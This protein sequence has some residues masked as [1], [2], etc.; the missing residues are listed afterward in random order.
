MNTVK[1][2]NKG[3]NIFKQSHGMLFPRNIFLKSIV[4][5]FEKYFVIDLHIYEN[6]AAKYFI[7]MVEILKKSL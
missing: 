3:N 7:N 4:A 5:L 6:I 1:S 2:D